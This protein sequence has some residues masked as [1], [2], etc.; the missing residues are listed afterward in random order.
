MS[1]KPIEALGSLS[2]TFKASKAQTQLQQ[3]VQMN[4]VMMA[5]AG[6]QAEQL[7]RKR[8]PASDLKKEARFQGS[9]QSGH[10]QKKQKKKQNEEPSAKSQHPTKGTHIDYSM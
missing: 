10:Q 9:S 3:R 7:A 1:F 6:R 4:E 2:H 8:I 5:E